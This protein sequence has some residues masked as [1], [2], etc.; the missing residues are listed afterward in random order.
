MHMY[1]QYTH[2]YTHAY[3]Y[4]HMYTHSY[5]YTHTKHIHAHIC[6]HTH[7]LIF[8]YTYIDTYDTYTHIYVHSLTHAHTHTPVL[9]N[10]IDVGGYGSFLSS[11]HFS[12][13][14]KQKCGL[15]TILWTDQENSEGLKIHTLESKIVKSLPGYI[16]FSTKVWTLPRCPCHRRELLEENGIWRTEGLATGRLLLSVACRQISLWSTQIKFFPV[17][18]LWT[19]ADLHAIIFHLI[20][21]W[22]VIVDLASFP[23]QHEQSTVWLENLLRNSCWFFVF[24]NFLHVCYKKVAGPFMLPS[25][26][27]RLWFRT[28]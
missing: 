28:K 9:V 4:T 10:D 23:P 26:K 2:S 14:R 25:L 5:K 17:A 21:K 7:I 24:W 11:N 19:R 1:I 15:K 16:C 22:I 13:H 8:T 18:G 27:G 6:I 3:M 12:E 20:Y